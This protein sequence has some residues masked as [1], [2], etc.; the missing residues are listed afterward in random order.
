MSVIIAGM[1]IFLISTMMDDRSAGLYGAASKLI[2]YLSM[3]STIYIMAIFP[4]ISKVWIYDKKRFMRIINVNI[5]GIFFILSP[6]MIV[7]YLWGKEILGFIYGQ[8]YG[9]MGFILF[10]LSIFL[11]INALN[12]LLSKVFIAAGKVFLLFCLASVTLLSSAILIPMFIKYIGLNGA[13]YGRVISS[14][15]SLALYIYLLARHLPRNTVYT[16]KFDSPEN[17]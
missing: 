4:L 12:D 17:G 15:L 2:F 7:T 10:L 11:V 16:S 14:I 8:E 1:D 5:F 3:I 9:S 6:I 13:A